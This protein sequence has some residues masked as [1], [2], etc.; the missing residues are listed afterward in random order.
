MN[1][2]LNDVNGNMIFKGDV[3]RREGSC[4]EYRVDFGY[5]SHLDSD[6][7]AYGFY[8]VDDQN[9]TSHPIPESEH[10]ILKLINKSLNYD[11]ITTSKSAGV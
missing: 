10:R 1:T 7:K 2:G 6:A 3:L 11:T 5:Y 9:Y 4:L 8:L